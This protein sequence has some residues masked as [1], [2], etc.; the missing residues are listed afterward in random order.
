MLKGKVAI[1]TGSTNGIGL[2]IAK[3]FG[4]EGADV[5]LNG[6]GE[7]PALEHLRK[8]TAKEH[9]VKLSLSSADMMK[10]AEITGTVDTRRAST[11]TST[12]SSTTPAFS[13]SRRRTSFR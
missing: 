5:V 12:S 9:G 8:D 6:V 7:A 11:A 3:A 2:G 10:P 1:V 13:T 4:A